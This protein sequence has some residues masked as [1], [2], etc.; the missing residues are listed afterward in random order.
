MKSLRSGFTGLV[1]LLAVAACKKELPLPAD[2]PGNNAAVLT[3]ATATTSG[4]VDTLTWNGTGV[5]TVEGMRYPRTFYT[6]EN[7]TVTLFTSHVRGGDTTYLIFKLPQVKEPIQPAR[8]VIGANKSGGMYYRNVFTGQ[9]SAGYIDLKN[10]EEEEKTIDFIINGAG[11]RT[12]TAG[13]SLPLQVN[14]DLKKVPRLKTRFPYNGVKLNGGSSVGA[15]II[16]TGNVDG[17]AWLAS[18][19]IKDS[20]GAFVPKTSHM[21]DGNNL[22]IT[23]ITVLPTDTLVLMAHVQNLLPG[24]NGTYKVTPAYHRVD[25]SRRNF[26]GTLDSGQVVISNY[27][28][29][30]G[31]M[32]VTITGRGKKTRLSDNSKEALNVNVTVRNVPRHIF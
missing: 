31:K 21:P 32:N 8:Y 20:A 29:N 5:M 6:L 10:P 14:L 16:S 28:L 7:D 13:V 3:P 12:N 24:A 26:E 9:V 30:T 4:K 19:Y 2:Q 25:F 1:L 22:I 23:S 27:S 17:V 18:G 11:T 15:D